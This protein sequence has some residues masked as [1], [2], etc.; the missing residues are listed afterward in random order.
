M[1]LPH[2]IFSLILKF[3][4]LYAYEDYHHWKARRNYQ[5][6]KCCCK[7]VALLRHIEYMPHFM[8]EGFAVIINANGFKIYKQRDNR[9]ASPRTFLKNPIVDIF[10]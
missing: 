1:L 6:Y 10:F 5:V 9:P 2:E 7:K 4:N 3:K 8:P